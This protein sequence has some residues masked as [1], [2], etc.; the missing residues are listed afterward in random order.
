MGQAPPPAAAPAARERCQPSSRRQPQT[1]I[2][3]EV[4]EKTPAKQSRECAYPSPTPRQAQDLHEQRQPTQE[5]RH[6][7][8]IASGT[9]S[10]IP[11]MGTP[12]RPKNSSSIGSSTTKPRGRSIVSRND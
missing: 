5:Q 8:K 4:H 9:H 1:M 3:T 2:A 6:D 11:P 10:D 12:P 7:P